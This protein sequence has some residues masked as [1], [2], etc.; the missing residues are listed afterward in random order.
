MN[1]ISPKH[2]SQTTVDKD[3]FGLRGYTSLFVEP[4]RSSLISDW[5]LQFGCCGCSPHVYQTIPWQE[6]LRPKAPSM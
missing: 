3:M 4:V 1:C 6:A 2:S 5:Q